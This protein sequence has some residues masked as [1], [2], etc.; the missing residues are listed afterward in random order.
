MN[1]RIK[2]REF[3]LDELKATINRTL[4]DGSSEFIPSG[5]IAGAGA[6]DWQ[7]IRKALSIWESEGILEILNDPETCEPHT[8]CVKML[9]FIHRCSSRPG[10]LNHQ[11]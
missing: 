8:P 10:F 7:Q 2:P 1:Q 11:E 3:F 9:K 5:T 6:R 4:D